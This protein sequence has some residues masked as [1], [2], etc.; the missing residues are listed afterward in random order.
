[1]NQFEITLQKLGLKA[2]ALALEKLKQDRL[3]RHEKLRNKCG[4][5]RI[6]ERP[7]EFSLQIILSHIQPS[8]TCWVWDGPRDWDGYGI[9]YLTG[10]CWRAHRF[11]FMLIN[12]Q[13]PVGKHILHHCDNPPCVRPDHL[14]A[15]TERDN[16]L[17]AYAKGRRKPPTHQCKLTDQQVREI[18][19]EYKFRDREHN[20]VEI[21]KRLRVSKIVAWGAAVGKTYQ[22]VQ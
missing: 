19:E 16:A 13:I 4:D 5:G 12:G 20:A 3:L 22:N 15:G 18:R 17:D 9:T 2:D 8:E 14:F 7:L 1:M 11:F 10:K 21:A 6:R